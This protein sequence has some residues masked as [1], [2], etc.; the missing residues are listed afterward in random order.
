[1][2]IRRMTAAD[3]S[4]TSAVKLTIS[5]RPTRWAS[6]LHWSARREMTSEKCSI[7]TKTKP[8]ATANSADGA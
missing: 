8:N 6:T 2:P 1:M 4:L 5:S 3:R 7:N